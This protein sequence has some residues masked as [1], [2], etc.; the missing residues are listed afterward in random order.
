MM[1]WGILKYMLMLLS[2]VLLRVVT[3]TE[4]QQKNYTTSYN[5]KFRGLNLKLLW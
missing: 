5:S 3:C 1:W 4:N 2:L